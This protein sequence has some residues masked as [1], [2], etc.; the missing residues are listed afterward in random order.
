MNQLYFST[1]I[2]VS[3]GPSHSTPESG[4]VGGF[5]V[6]SLQPIRWNLWVFNDVGKGLESSICKDQQ[7][8]LL[9]GCVLHRP[10]NMIVR[11][12]VNGNSLPESMHFPSSDTTS[13]LFSPASL[14]LQ[15]TPS[16]S[17]SFSELH[18]QQPHPD[19]RMCPAVSLIRAS[20]SGCCL[21][22]LSLS[23][24]P[25]ASPCPLSSF[26]SQLKS[27]FLIGLYPTSLP[28]INL[29]QMQGS[30]PMT[31]SLFKY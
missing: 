16:W 1:E 23:F 5:G 10:W 24:L 22:C 14:I 15:P 18:A 6:E 29:S 7:H 13:S 20:T 27:P 8:H 9:Q 26:R 19:S 21:F 4:E 2:R 28:R 31:Y 12:D 25:P 3:Q 11:K 30:P 17:P